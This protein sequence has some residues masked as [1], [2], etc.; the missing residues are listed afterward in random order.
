MTR[1]SVLFYLR[2]I[3]EALMSVQKVW[4]SACV[5]WKK[6]EKKDVNE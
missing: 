2:N 5:Y 6:K 1:L 4:K 3:L